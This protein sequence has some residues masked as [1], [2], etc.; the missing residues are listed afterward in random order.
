VTDRLQFPAVRLLGR[1][2]IF[3]ESDKALLKAWFSD[4]PA[5][6]A[7][8]TFQRPRRPRST[9]PGSQSHR[10]NGFIAQIAQATG[11]DFDRLKLELKQKAIA[12]GW[13]FDTVAYKTKEG[14]LVEMA[15]A[16]S[17]TV[18]TVEEASALIETVE[19]F[20]AERGVILRED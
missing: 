6:F 8:I 4:L 13:P 17:E 2:L 3:S 1:D 7:M 19:Q 16:K 10:I 15:I 11:D 9:G 20:A 14:V 5:P 18:A 12:R